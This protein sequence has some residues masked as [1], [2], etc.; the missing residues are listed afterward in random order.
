MTFTS[1]LYRGKKEEGGGVFNYEHL[2]LF[3]TF[4]IQT[5]R[6]QFAFIVPEVWSVAD[7]D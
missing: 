3:L 5:H 6:S 1:L 7:S 2:C 4:C